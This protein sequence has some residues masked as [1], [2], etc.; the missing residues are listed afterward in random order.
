MKRLTLILLCWK[1]LSGQDSTY[2]VTDTYFYPLQDAQELTVSLDVKLGQ[3]KLNP[4]QASRAIAGSIYYNPGQTRTQVDYSTRG[5]TGQ[6]SVE[7]VSAA[8]DSN[9]DLKVDIKMTGFKVESLNTPYYNELD[10]ALPRAV[11]SRYKLNFGM[12]DAD[13]DFTGL[14]V[15]SLLLDCGMSDVDLVVGEPNTVPC[16]SVV[17]KSGLG[18]LRSEG[19]GYLQAKTVRLDVGL[20]SATID[21]R[22]HTR[23][24]T[25]IDADVGLG[26]LHLVLPTHSNIDVEVS[27]FLSSVD[28]S[29]LVQSG[30]NH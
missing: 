29:G 25:T 2:F 8:L 5:R 7:L 15:R 1:V 9:E 21:M 18:D 28:M 22:G 27:T 6:L 12:G 24:S 16:D 14:A 30:D 11:P 20:G 3:L 13:L 10:F 23:S 17:L 26:G 19:L 4:N